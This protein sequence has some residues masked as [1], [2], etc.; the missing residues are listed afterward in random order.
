MDSDQL[1]DDSELNRYHLTVFATE[2][3]LKDGAACQDFSVEHSAHQLLRY[4]PVLI[5]RYDNRILV[6]SS[7]YGV[8]FSHGSSSPISLVC[9]H[10]GYGF[11]PDNP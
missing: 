10:A 2:P 11:G 9:H 5:L 1:E 3:E 6:I 8:K 7:N 4:H